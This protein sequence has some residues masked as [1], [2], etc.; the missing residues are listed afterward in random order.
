MKTTNQPSSKSL[1]EQSE[2]ILKSRQ[3]TKGLPLSDSETSELTR[4]LQLS[5]IEP[6]LQNQELKNNK[7]LVVP[8]GNMRINI[9]ELIDFEKVN[10]LLEGFNQSTG[11]VTAILDLNGNVLSKS[12][13]RQICTE[14]HRVNPETS[15]NCTIS[16]TMLAD[17]LGNGEKYHFYKCH[18]GL[19]DVAV[20]IIVNGEHI[21]NL[22]SGQFFFDEPD[23]HFFR[24]QAQ[25]YKFDESSY[26]KALDNV[27]IVSMEKVKTVMAFLL[28]MTQLISGITFQRLEQLQLNEAIRKSEER[29][30]NTLDHLLEG[31]QIIGFDWKYIYLNHTAEIHNKRPKEELLGQRYMDM[32]PGIEETEV[33]QV[34]KQTLETRVPAH[35]DNKFF[36]PDG[37]LGWFDLSIQP[38]P[39]GVFILSVDITERKNVE[40]ALQKSEEKYRLIADNSD[41]WIYW[42]APDGRLNYVSP[43]CERVTGYSPKEFVNHPE[44]NHEIV[45]EADQ[46]KV[47]QHTHFSRLDNSP[48]DLEFRIVT[49]AGKIRWVNHSCSPIYDNEGKYLGRRGTNRNITERKLQEEQLFE[50]EFRFSKLYENGPFGMVMADKDFG[51]KKANP[52]FCEIMGYSEAEL[53]QLTFKDISLAEDLKNDLPNVQKLMSREL[54]VYKTEKRYIRKDGQVIWGS[55]TVTANYDSEG[56]FLYNLGIIEDITPR[57]H[58]EDALRERENK[59]S[60]LLNLLPVGISIL[61]E[62][63]KI[64]YEN[65]ALENILDITREGM[66]RGDYRERKYLR[67]DET[68]KPAVE[69]ASGRVF[70]EKKAL[71]N[72]ITGIVKEDGQTVWTNV[73]AVPVEFADWKVVLVT[74]DITDLKQTE[75]ELKKSKKL[76]SETETVGKVGGWEFNIDTMAQTWTDEVYRIHE[77]EPGFS[78]KV[79][80]GINFYA[81]SSRPLIERAVQRALEFGEPFDLELEIIT[82]KGNLR[83][84]HSVGKADFENRRIYGF[85]QDVTER[86]LAEEE[87]Q[88][89]NERISTATR[90]SQ[91]GIWDWDIQNNVLTWDEQM[92]K[93]YGLKKDEFTGA[94]EAW[95]NGLHPDDRDFGQNQTRLALTGEKDYDTEFRVVWPD[96]SIHIDKARGEVFRNEQGEPIRMVGINYDI[97][98]DKKKD[99][100]IREK[101][102]EFRKLSANVPDLLYQFTRKPD[103][104]YF[105]PIASEGIR[106]IFGCSPEDVIDDFT[107]IGRV[108]HPQD[109]E[110]VIR[111]IE[112]SAEH[113]TYFTCEFRV[114]I[115]GREI[116]WIYS[117]ST[118]E[119]LPDGSITWYGFNTDITHKKL[120]E[121]ALQENASKL[122]LAMQ[123][124]NMAWWEMNIATGQVTFDRRKSDMLGYP[125]EKFKHYT[126]FTELLHPDDFDAAMKSMKKHLEGFLDKYEIEYRIQ[127]S[128]GEYKWFYDI[129]AI[130]KRDHNG[131]PLNVTG[132]VIDISWRKQAEEKLKLSEERY[133]NIFE[134]A[135]IGIYRTT[136]DGQILMANQTLIKMLGFNSF[137]ELAQRNLKDEGYEDKKKRRE[138]QKRIERNGSVIGFESVWMTKD[139]RPVI[140]SENA[141][142]FYDG[143]NRVIYYEGT[144]EDITK[145]KQIEKTL[146]ESEEKFRLAFATNPDAITI[147]RLKD[148]VYASVNTGFTQ[149]FGYT[150][151]EILGK[152]SLEINMWYNPEDRKVFVNELKSKGK[153][154]NFEA[155]L[156]TKSGIIKDTLVSSTIMEFDGETHLLSTTKDITE[157]KLAE[158]ALR[159]SEEKFR[160]LIESIPLPVTYVSKEGEIVFRNERF[161]QVIGYTYDEVPTVDKW[162]LSAYPDE[163]YREWVVSNWESAMDHA[164]KT[165]TDILPKEYRITCKDGSVRIF[166]V[167]GIIIDDN[168]LITFIDITDRKIAEYEIKK[169]NETLEER[170]EERTSQLQEA[171]KELE[172]FSYSV[173]HDLRAPLRHINGFVDLL[174]ENYTGL[175]PE[176]GLHYLEI[177]ANSSRHMGTLIDD[178]LQFSRTGRKEMQQIDLDM[179]AVLKEVLNQTKQDARD[180]KIEWHISELPVLTGDQSLL[181]MVWYNLLSNA[182][183]FTKAKEPAIIQIGHYEEKNEY[184]FFVRDNG[185]GFDMRYAHKLF[186]VFQRLHTTKEFEG[187]GIGLANVRRIILKHGGRTWAES[188]LNQGATFYFTLPKPKLSEK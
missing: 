128:T 20:P 27:P 9:L 66:E 18:N 78:P 129:G 152:T 50:S 52:A 123:S 149:V 100:K 144:I 77:V 166:V 160:Q 63:Q 70:R 56:Q 187:T 188:Q 171:N 163:T 185:A 21:A 57:K 151:E 71:H 153:I 117:K 1:R 103:G 184:V 32:W 4:E 91:V 48:H 24:K 161:V 17:E 105:V 28:D 33:F 138:F 93:L 61:D 173:S 69:F 40:A 60:T 3:A 116:Q 79:D 62:N 142:A 182:I 2:E 114:Q 54:A 113:L 80:A 159:E 14:F 121:E 86:K 154:E 98:E 110:R 112:Y 72:V 81:P 133:R 101:D 177:I 12:G 76:L 67:N 183:K 165:N 155:R 90:A 97:T 162:W 146:Q 169:L 82:A 95:V 96:G 53:Q 124:A 179:N 132:F 120:A 94:Y 180:R 84:V 145:R 109:A 16:D 175:L 104:T 135:V 99:E 45:F 143:N 168:L 73:S 111:D 75:K 107:P 85:F 29:S 55:L 186:G 170:V 158:E 19:V 126:D 47:R 156:C 39:E 43:A 115:P 31:C 141:K 65:Q 36:F 150:E 174:T 6:E 83:K 74:S 26:L 134:S 37:S 34:I 172:A 8:T 148:G 15:R 5:Q 130:V 87:I 137:Q 51:F 92:Y 49:K 167:S 178:L 7:E 108:I 139:G 164:I 35:L 140:V 41:D 10:K 102:L 88:K 23:R 157:R 58:A 68:P 64:V 42:V 38:V 125:A 136:P 131:S 11:F 119:R 25:K 181:R 122:S 176:K 89:L 118:P 46:T 59:L 44:L 106:N 147:T 30:R 22:F 127:T 13:W